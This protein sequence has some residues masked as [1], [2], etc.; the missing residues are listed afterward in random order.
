LEGKNSQIPNNMT[1]FSQTKI[2]N[3]KKKERKENEHAFPHISYN[4]PGTIP[5][6]QS[7]NPLKM[8]PTQGEKFL[9]RTTMDCA[10]RSRID[11]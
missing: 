1:L 3:K 8:E 2:A 9:N 5:I 4:V 7:N 10:V 11:K 6:A